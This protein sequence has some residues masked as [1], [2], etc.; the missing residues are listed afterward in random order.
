MAVSVMAVFGAMSVMGVHD[1]GLFELDGNAVQDGA[2]DDWE[3]VYDGTD[4]SL[5]SIFL[6]DGPSGPSDEIFIGGG[7][8]DINDIDEWAWTTGNVPD[9]DD[10]LNAYAAAYD[11]N[12]KLI[13]YFGLDRYANNGD[14]QVGFWFLQEPV[15]LVGDGTFSGV[16]SEGDVLVLSHFTNGGAVDNIEVFQ[17]VGTG[18]DTNDTLNHIA[19]GAECGLEDDDDVCAIVN[20]AEEPAPWPY[21]PKFGNTGFFPT[22]SFYEGGIDLSA[23]GLELGCGGTFLAETRSSQEPTAQLKDL[24]LGDFTLCDLEVTKTGDTLSKVG[25]PASYSITIE[26][27]GSVTLY[28]QSIIDSV[29]GD[30]TDGSNPL[31]DASDCGASLAVGDTCTITA[32]RT[33]M[34]GDA[35]PL[36]NTVTATYDSAAALDGDEVSD[37]DDH[38]VN[39]FQPSVT[40]DKSG[41]ATSKVGDPVDYTITVDN[42]SS[43]DTPDLSCTVD[44]TLLGSYGP[45]VIASGDDWV[46]NDSRVVEGTDPDPLVNTATVTCSPAGFPNVLTDSDSHSVDLFG[47]SI[48]FDKTGDT[49][50]KVGDDVDYTITIGNTSTA[51]TPDLTCSVNDTLLGSFGPY[52]IASGDSEVIN[53]SWTVQAAD[54]DPLVNTATVTCSVDG[55][56]N[57][58]TASDGHSVNLF[59]PQVAIDK[60]GDTLSKVGDDVDYTI[61]VTNTSSTDTPDLTCSV[62]DTLLGGFGPY[63]LASGASEIINESR[64][65]DAADPDPLINTATVTCSPAGFPNVLTASDSVSSDVLH[66]DYTVTKDCLTD[67]VPPG[68]TAIFSVT[69]ENTGDIDLIVSADEDLTDAGG[70]IVA[71]DTFT[72]AVAETRTFEV[73]ITAGSDPLVVNTVNATATLPAFTEL[74]NV[75]ER[76]ATAE[77]EVEGGATRTRGFWQ[78]HIDYTTHVFEDHLGGTIDLG[79]KQ[80]TSIDEL[81]GIFW[82]NNA[83]ESDGSKRSNV[84]KAQM[85]GSA[86]LL[87]AILNTG[88]DNGAAVP[89]DTVTGLDLITAMQN[90][91]AA[92]DRHEILRLSGLLDAYNNSGDD[93][94]II[95]N[96]G[97][98]IGRADP[99][100]AKEIAD[101]AFAD[102]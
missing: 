93:I 8:K 59:Q 12:G 19:T 81:M 20:D 46:I 34:A 102:C 55:F 83:K 2:I 88:L 7:S 77:C 30:L 100:F 97:E 90:A 16:H 5:V 80:I 3:N 27:T 43:A 51:D 23:L 33:V 26:N 92:G 60:T 89:I 15:G 13:I 48:T 84:C 63:V 11:D 65:T 72:L 94:A 71:G 39:L 69:F 9:K 44:D 98:L 31:I 41:T 21:D 96:D 40:I 17:W 25:D 14:A 50:S 24:A 66:P 37:A 38:S 1:A 47:P 28:K 79:W 85:I 86:Q 56:P 57:V 67:V 74:D 52:I 10:I 29:L 22:G 35:D 68:G 76:S 45:Q 36:P 6:A 53:T 87:A 70:T 58:L 99:R 78:T 49:L 73:S 75:L 54:P 32:T 95:D 42:T 91:L 62:N 101:L 64:V 4:S 61:T 82:A 18:G